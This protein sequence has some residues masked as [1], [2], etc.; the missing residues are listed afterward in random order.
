[1]AISEEII[2]PESNFFVVNRDTTFCK[3]HF[4]MRAVFCKKFNKTCLV[5]NNSPTQP[6]YKINFVETR[7]NSDGDKIN[8]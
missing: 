2:V 3:V 5:D 1:M 6:R 8:S 7:V 4:E